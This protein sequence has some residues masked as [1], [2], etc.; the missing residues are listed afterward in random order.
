MSLNSDNK[1][2]PQLGVYV[3]RVEISEGTYYGLT[4]M[5][6]RPTLNKD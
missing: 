5:G 1:F 2:I 6:Y 4:N 3:S